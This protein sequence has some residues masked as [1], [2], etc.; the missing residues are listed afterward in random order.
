MV[1][2]SDYLDSSWKIYIFEIRG[3]ELV[4]VYLN[5]EFFHGDVDSDLII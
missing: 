2:V 4:K 5:R 3:G 1:E